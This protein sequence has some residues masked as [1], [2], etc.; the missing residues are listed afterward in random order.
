MSESTIPVPSERAIQLARGAYDMHV[1]SGP[2]LLP[3]INNDIELAQRF[4]ARGL[5]G[6]VIKSHFVPSAG[7]AALANFAVPGMRVMGSVVLNSAIGGLNSMAVEM[8]ARE[9]ARVVWCPTFDALNE[10]AGRVPPAPG[11][12]LPFWAKMQHQ[13][14]DE[15]V[16]SDPV[17]VVDENGRVLPAMIQVLKSIAKHD[18]VFATAHLSRDEIFAVVDAAIEVGVRQIVITHPEFPS[19][20]INVEDQKALAAKGALLERCFTTPYSG[21]VSWET[22]LSNIRAVG[23]EHSLLSTDLG[24]AGSVPVEDGIP[25]WIDRLLAAGFTEDEIR[26]MAIDNSVRLA[27]GGR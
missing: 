11:A 7:R 27:E 13:L 18:M 25:L 22:I 5:K 15:G 20:R 6:Y 26:V 12:K 14:R 23:P 24:Q 21:K 8:A 17:L 19:Q 3:R 4:K 2:D 16:N 9:N 10:T 1:H